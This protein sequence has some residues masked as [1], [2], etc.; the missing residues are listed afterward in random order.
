MKKVDYILSAFLIMTI[1]YVAICLSFQ[2]K[3]DTATMVA[4]LWSALATAILGAIALFQNFRYKKLA[5]SVSEEMKNIQVDIKQL[6]GEMASAVTVLKTIESSKYYADIRE[7]GLRFVGSGDMFTEFFENEELAFQYNTINILTNTDL[8]YK[9][10]IF[11]NDTFAF[12]LRNMGEKKIRDF[13]CSKF[14]FPPFITNNIDH[15]FCSDPCDIEEGQTVMVCLINIPDP[16][17]IADSNINF[18]FGMQNLLADNFES[19]C[20]VWF[21]DC[22]D[23]VSPQISFSTPKR[24]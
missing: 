17:K 3:G 8:N 13:Y 23:H 18:K 21:E 4:G 7:I 20:N 5:D 22:G 14:E 1:I 10:L 2:T 24:V 11:A 16:D 6:T 12:C 15:F 19:S 9:D